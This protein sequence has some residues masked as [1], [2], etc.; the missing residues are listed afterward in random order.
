[1][2]RLIEADVALAGLQNLKHTEMLIPMTLVKSTYAM[3]ESALQRLG[4]ARAGGI[5][6]WMRHVSSNSA[7]HHCD[8]VAAE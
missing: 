4:S 6:D 3:S 5:R 2:Y 7:L 8:A 1:M